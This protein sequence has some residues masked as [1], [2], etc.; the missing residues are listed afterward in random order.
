[1]HATVA[2]TLC[3]QMG[4]FQARAIQYVEDA[5][6]GNSPSKYQEI[7]PVWRVLKDGSRKQLSRS[8]VINV[9]LANFSRKRGAPSAC[10]VFLDRLMVTRARARV[11]YVLQIPTRQSQGLLHVTIVK[12][13]RLQRAV[14]SHAHHAKLGDTEL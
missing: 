1:M 3:S 13:E 5:P 4:N 12:S 10:P 11:A 2:A 9:T 8:L 14:V 7:F 6:L